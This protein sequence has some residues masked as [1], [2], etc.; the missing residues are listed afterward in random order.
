MLMRQACGCLP[1][2]G[3]LGAA[4]GLGRH[5]KMPPVVSNWTPERSLDQMDRA[6]IQTA[7]LSITTM[8]FNNYAERY[9]PASR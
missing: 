9:P 4:A 7:M 6:G 1:R 2:R 3:F 5:L 8:V